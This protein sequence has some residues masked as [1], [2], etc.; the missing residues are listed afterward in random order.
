MDSQAI[1]NTM[2]VLETRPINELV[3]EATIK[4]C[5]VSETP[6]RNKTVINK[7]VGRQI[8]ATLPGA[9]V[10]GFFDP[11][12]GD[13]VEHSRQLVI[14]EGA[15]ELKDLTRPY[16]FVS[17]DPPWYQDFME[18][19]MVRTYLMCKAYLWTRQYSEASSA[20]NKGQSMELDEMSMSG[21]YEGDVFVFTQAT[22][23]KLCI[24][25][26]KYE[27]CF[28]GAAIMSTYA[29]QYS[30]LAEQVENILGRRYYVLD[31][32]LIPKEEKVTLEYALQL[33]WNLTDAV[34]MQL[35]ARGAEGKYSIQGIYT[36]NGEI[37]A[38]LQDVT[39]LEYLRVT[40]EI[41]S[42]ETVTLAS[43]MQAVTQTWAAKTPTE[44][45]APE[46]LSGETVETPSDPSVQAGTATAPT[47]TATA[48]ASSEYSAVEQTGNPEVVDGSAEP[49]A[50]P[51]SAPE[52]EP[53][54]EP[55][56][57]FTA[58]EP[59]AEPEATPEAEPTAEPEG[60]PAGEFSA[61]EPETTEPVVE[62]VEPSEPEVEPT[63]D[64]V[65]VNAELTA[66]IE[67]LEGDI[68]TKDARITELETALNAY[69]MAEAEA[70]NQKKTEM[71]DSYK[72]MLT[73]EEIAPIAEKVGEYSLD[74]LE[75]QLAVTYSR[76]Q[77]A[78]AAGTH[79]RGVQVSVTGIP[80]TLE[81]LPEFMKQAMEIDKA[82]SLSL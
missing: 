41:N 10:V 80:A 19:G 54:G 6:N 60:E 63:T 79:Q 44:P 49:S 50:E 45:E 8:A 67:T 39:S 76:K 15:I 27:P 66:R 21:Y 64:Y 11:D 42:D 28:E 31:G 53:T 14:K 58:E 59:E 61:E 23:D 32:Q 48:S 77:Q 24:L 20:L 68:A 52:G 40:L 25:G 7:E 30:L 13:F 43:E 70:E 34:Y 69:K 78:A 9:P 17:F 65:V 2:E 36:E 4:V 51:E 1:V 35:A 75:A 56:G 73:D 18:D 71:L 33:G 62:P 46:S 26:A 22:L 12:T 74:Q 37:F 29:K 82:N 16:G 57:E 55:E 5:Y 81:N 47:M 3:T 72:A 38:I